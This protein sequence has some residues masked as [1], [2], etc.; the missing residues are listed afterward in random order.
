MNTSSAMH[1]ASSL[2]YDLRRTR[3]LGVAERPFQRM[4]LR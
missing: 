3:V 2:T 1:Y 4:E